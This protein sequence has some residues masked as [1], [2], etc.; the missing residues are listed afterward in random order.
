MA[1]VPGSIGSVGECVGELGTSFSTALTVVV[2]WLVS[3]K[4]A[5]SK[6]VLAA[7]TDCKDPSFFAALAGDG[8]GLSD[9]VRTCL[10]LMDIVGAVGGWSLDAG[11][12]APLLLS[13]G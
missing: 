10:P 8:G 1:G 13:P 6:G 7:K 9:L 11:Y 4:S 5:G 12:A 2:D 3:P